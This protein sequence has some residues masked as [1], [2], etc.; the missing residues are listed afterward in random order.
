MTLS[1]L[2]R[3]RLWF[4]G[5]A[6]LIL[7]VNTTVVRTLPSADTDQL[8]GY[9]IVFDFVLVIPML[10]WLFIVRPIG[11]SIR[12]VVPVTIVGAAAAWFVL[13]ATLRG[14]VWSV[15]WPFELLIVT[16]EI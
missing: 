8:L 16:I 5:F 1:R 14:L 3:S 4:L 11:K 6:A 15:M 13:P 2:N 12:K 7:I 9:A 10:Y